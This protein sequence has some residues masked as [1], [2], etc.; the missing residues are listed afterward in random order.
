MFLSIF[1]QQACSLFNLVLSH[2]IFDALIH[3]VFHFEF[4]RL[5]S[6]G[7]FPC[8]RLGRCE[9]SRFKFAKFHIVEA[10]VVRIVQLLP[11][12]ALKVSMGFSFFFAGSADSRRGLDGRAGVVLITSGWR[13]ALFNFSNSF[14]N[15]AALLSED[16]IDGTGDTSH[17]SEGNNH[18]SAGVAG[19]R[20]V[21]RRNV[22]HLLLVGHR[23]VNIISVLGVH[24]VISYSFLHNRFSNLSLSLDKITELQRINLRLTS[25]KLVP[26]EAV[27]NK[28]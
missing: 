15:R 13:W 27:E 28:E 1:P 17:D 22:A 4:D 3:V 11:G 10:C 5:E 21:R 6:D 25:V 2:S 14:L 19:L 8:N 12:A 18:Y 7:L 26:I 9:I 24:L 20:L 23:H 16:E